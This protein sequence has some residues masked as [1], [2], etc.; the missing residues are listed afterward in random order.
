MF[1]QTTYVRIEKIN[2]DTFTVKDS[3]GVTFDI[4]KQIIQTES[5]SANHHDEE[6]KMTSTELIE[7]IHTIKDK[8]C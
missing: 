6:K 2:R 1:S 8:V 7:V 5:F 4:D 3:Y